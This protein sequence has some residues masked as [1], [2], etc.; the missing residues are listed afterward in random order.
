MFGTVQIKPHMLNIENY[1]IS[2]ARR[3]RD[4]QKDRTFPKI[5]ISEIE[6]GASDW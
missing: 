3:S 2:N 6:S 1:K 5:L 4:N